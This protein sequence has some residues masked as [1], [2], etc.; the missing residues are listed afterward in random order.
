[1]RI[2]GVQ[3]FVPI[4]IEIADHGPQ[5]RITHREI[6]EVDR[7][8]WMSHGIIAGNLIDFSEDDSFQQMQEFHVVRQCD[9]ALQHKRAHQHVTP[10]FNFLLGLQRFPTSSISMD[11]W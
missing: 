5:I 2:G 11:H 6:D 4:F 3:S 1:M 10:N 8:F 9:A 7:L